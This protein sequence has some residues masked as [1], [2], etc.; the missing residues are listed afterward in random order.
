M[1]KHSTLPSLF[2]PPSS[3]SLYDDLIQLASLVP[4]DQPPLVKLCEVQYGDKSELGLKAATKL[5]ANQVVVKYAGLFLPSKGN[6]V[7]RTHSLFTVDRR[8]TNF[9]H[10]VI[11]GKIVA[12]FMRA[13][14]ANDQQRVLHIAG[15]MIN[16]SPT[17]QNVQLANDDATF[18]TLN[19]RKWAMR[20]FVATR[21]IEPGEELLWNYAPRYASHHSTN[22]ASDGR[23]TKP[24]KKQR[25]MNPKRL[26][27]Q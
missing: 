24:P 7:S 9:Q 17:N 21:D 14:E 8:D 1:R 20:D 4:S 2:P 3:S 18:K 27:R 16:A 23:P 15:A 25:R 10:T 5:K 19:D 13:S 26:D 22:D 6:N 11:D 12:D